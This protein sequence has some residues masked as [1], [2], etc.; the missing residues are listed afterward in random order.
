MAKEHP[1]PN[2][3][4]PSSHWAATEAWQML[5]KLPVGMLPGFYRF[6]PA[7]EIVGALVKIAKYG[8][9]PG[10]PEHARKRL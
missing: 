8:P 2:I 10:S 7:G 9:P 4:R 3:L 5:D 1:Y 6:Q